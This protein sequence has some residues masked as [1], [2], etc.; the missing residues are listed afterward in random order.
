[1]DDG[2]ITGESETGDK[3]MKMTRSLRKMIDCHEKINSDIS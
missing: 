2:D 1:M 3:Y